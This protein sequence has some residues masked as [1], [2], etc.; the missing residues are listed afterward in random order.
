VMDNL[1]P[2][3]ITLGLQNGLFIGSDVGMYTEC[4]NRR[5]AT[6][7]LVLALLALWALAACGKKGPLRLPKPGETTDDDQK[8]AQ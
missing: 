3:D 6:R 5:A 4:P 7:R 1:R 2:G 8:A